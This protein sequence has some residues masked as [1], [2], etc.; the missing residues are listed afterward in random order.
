MLA[1]CLRDGFTVGQKVRRVGDIFLV[2]PRL[3][4]EYLK[5][6]TKAHSADRQVRIYGRI[7]FEQATPQDI[8]RGIQSGQ[9]HESV[10]TEEEKKEVEEFIKTL[11]QKRIEE[12]KVADELLGIPEE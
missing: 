1:R 8:L 4:E 12:E 3:E 2:P 11:A 9:V 10:L 6:I 5:G 7:L